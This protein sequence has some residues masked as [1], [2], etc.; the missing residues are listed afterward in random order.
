MASSSPLSE[1]PSSPPRTPSRDRSRKRGSY[2]PSTPRTARRLRSASR[3]DPQTPRQPGKEAGKGKEK[4]VERPLTLNFL[5]RPVR[6]MISHFAKK[7]NVSC[8][9]RDD[10]SDDD[11]AIGDL[12]EDASESETSSPTPGE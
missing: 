3:D 12:Y 1:P 9:G 7:H 8:D 6:D 10:H 11:D 4:E 5:N 2:D